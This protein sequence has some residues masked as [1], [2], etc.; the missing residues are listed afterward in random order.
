MAKTTVGL[1]GTADF[2]LFILHIKVLSTV[3]N[4]HQDNWLE[5]ARKW[6]VLA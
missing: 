2:F 3:D 5:E 4:V 6:Q 1:E